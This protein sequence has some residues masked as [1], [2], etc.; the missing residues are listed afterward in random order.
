M[1]S[2][3]ECKKESN[4]T[5]ALFTWGKDQM[6]LIGFG[7]CLPTECKDSVESYLSTHAKEDISKIY[8][9]QN[10]LIFIDLQAKTSLSSAGLFFAS[11]FGILMIFTVLGTC[12]YQ[13]AF[14]INFNF[15]VNF[16]SM[17]VFN[18]DVEGFEFLDGM[19]AFCCICIMFLHDY[20]F[21][22]GVVL[23][24]RK[25]YS[26]NINS[27]F[28]TWVRSFNFGVDV[29][30]YIAGFLMAI[31]TL[32]EIKRKGKNFS[33]FKC[34]LRRLSRYLPIYL[35]IIGVDRCF[36]KAAPGNSRSV[37]S[38]VFMQNL[39]GGWWKNLLFVHNILTEG[40]TPYLAWTWSIAADFQFYIVSVFLVVI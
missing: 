27:L 19:R 26:D 17:F 6:N 36:V 9:K 8:S 12:F 10:D 18:E 30:F 22:M 24:N 4:S 25:E 28:T 16:K 39:Q 21:S 29:F 32:Q 23:K 37:I 38:F 40:K 2:I 11:M 34:I 1:E 33:I 15:W 7:F 35:F 20:I 31:L 3:S 13:K 5:Y 14:F